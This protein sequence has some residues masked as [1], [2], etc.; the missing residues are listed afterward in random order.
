MEFY[1]PIR[2]KDSNKYLM[3]LE[4][5]L[6]VHGASPELKDIIN[7][8]RII[9]S[10]K[11][12]AHLNE[13]CKDL[14]TPKAVGT[15][16]NI[17]YLSDI[18]INL[19][20][21]S[22]IQDNLKEINQVFNTIH[23]FHKKYF[24]RD[25]SDL[26][27]INIYGSH[28]D[29]DKC[30]NNNNIC[31][32]ELASLKNQ[33]LMSFSRLAQIFKEHGII[34]NDPPIEFY[35]M[36]NFLEKYKD[37]FHMIEDS[38]MNKLQYYINNLE[39]YYI[40]I[41]EKNFKKAATV[42]SLLKYFENETYRSVGAYLHIVVG[43]KDLPPVLYM[44]SAIDNLGFAVDNI[45]KRNDCVDIDFT[46]K[47]LRVAKYV[48]RIIDAIQLSK[49]QNAPDLSKLKTLSQSLNTAR[50]ENNL[51]NITTKLEEFMSLLNKLTIQLPD[52]N[53]KSNS[54]TLGPKELRMILMLLRLV[55]DIYGKL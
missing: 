25:Y 34:F 48:E 29:S 16:D 39:K 7:D 20:F 14:C 30:N 53:I 36:N 10:N 24:K 33:R 4:W 35:E 15:V 55:I 23:N 37:T 13:T 28:F 51:I 46:W 5:D 42:F 41:K 9:Y 19:N 17:S 49:V 1:I 32:N 44:D 18:D 52:I 11:L 45:V 50:K 12:R 2:C 47:M 43:L 3:E 26:F 54:K 27:D 21:S 31:L 22:K 40:L 38:K 6:L 8:F